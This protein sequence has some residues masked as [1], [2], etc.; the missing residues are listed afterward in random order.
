[1]NALANFIAAKERK[2]ELERHLA[3]CIVETERLQRILLDEFAAE[4]VSSKRDV[5]TGKLVYLSRQVWARAAV[6]RAETAEA[7]SRHDGAL[8]AFAKLDFNVQSLSAYFREELRNRAENH[9]PVLDL[10]LLVPE[11]LRP[12]I[13]L[14]DDHKLSVKA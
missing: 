6:D 12:Y 13:A 5:H 4:G 11:D 8:A 10:S 2:K 3:D 7:L 1:V 14:T 9:D